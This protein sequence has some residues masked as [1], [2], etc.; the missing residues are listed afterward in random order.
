MFCYQN[1]SN[2]NGEINKGKKMMALPKGKSLVRNKIGCGNNPIDSQFKSN[3]RLFISTALQDGRR[4]CSP[5]R[6]EPSS[7]THQLF[8]IFFPGVCPDTY[9]ENCP[10][11][12]GEE[13][14]Y[15]SQVGL[16][17]A[18]NNQGK[19]PHD[20]Q[21]GMGKLALFRNSLFT[22]NKTEFKKAKPARM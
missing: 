6:T 20:I 18:L 14:P 16:M 13:R 1:D 3:A 22:R 21:Q 15:E 4:E 17:R 19:M 8:C 5:G 7:L 2:V 12:P 9:F 11:P 10:W